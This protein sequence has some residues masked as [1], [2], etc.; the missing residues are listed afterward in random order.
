[1]STLT[2]ISAPKALA[3]PFCNVDTIMALLVQFFI[4]SKLLPLGKHRT[5]TSRQSFCYFT[6]NRS[7]TL[8]DALSQT[9]YMNSIHGEQCSPREIKTNHNLVDQWLVISSSVCGSN[10]LKLC[11]L[12]ANTKHLSRTPINW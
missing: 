12:T 6:A 7:L 4:D 10:I 8:N 9:A 1:M 5:V 3:G 11:S 2:P